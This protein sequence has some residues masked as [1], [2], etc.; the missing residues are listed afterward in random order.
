MIQTRAAT[1][2]VLFHVNLCPSLHGSN[3]PSMCS[4]NE[5]TKLSGLA[6]PPY[7]V[8]V[9]KMSDGPEGSKGSLADRLLA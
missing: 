4:Y 7:P 9:Q 5:H 2:S 1:V 3:Q 8:L 6:S